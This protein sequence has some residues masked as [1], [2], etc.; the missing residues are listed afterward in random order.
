MNISIKRPIDG[1]IQVFQEMYPDKRCL[2]VYTDSYIPNLEDKNDDRLYLGWCQAWEDDDAQ[3]SWRILISGLVSLND[4]VAILI[5]ELSHI[6]GGY[7]HGKD[8]KK[9]VRLIL[10]GYIKWAKK[11]LGKF[12]PKF[13]LRAIYRETWYQ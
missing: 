7:D 6:I 2:I 5:H 11:N 13:K 3:P 8:F 4:S 1:V 10:S 9:A 12:A